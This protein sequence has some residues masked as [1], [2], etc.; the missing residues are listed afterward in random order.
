MKTYKLYDYF[1][2]DGWYKTQNYAA[3][4]SYYSQFNLLFH[5]GVDFGHKNKKILIKC[6]F[7]SARVV[8]E[9]SN[10][11]AYGFYVVLWDMEQECA[12][13]FAHMEDSVRVN[14]GDMVKAG[15]VIGE[16]GTSG[17]STGEHTHMN[18]MITKEG[19]RI[20]RTKAQNW[21]YLDPQHPLDTGK[22][23]SL[24]NVPQYKVEWVSPKYKDMTNDELLKYYKVKT[25][26]ELISMVD[27]QLKFLED[28]RKKNK[29]LQ[30]E[31]DTYQQKYEEQLDANTELKASFEQYKSEIQKEIEDLKRANM[32]S[33]AQATEYKQENTE[34]KKAL[35][36]IYNT[37]QD[38][39]RIISEAE[40]SI[41][42]ED[43]NRKL[44]DAFSELDLKSK[45]TISELENEIS[46]LKAQLATKDL[47]EHDLE[48]LLKALMQK[49]VKLIKE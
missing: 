8:L 26:E 43:E 28:E 11:G 12:L 34:K 36:S 41:S 9:H 1:T 32:A 19:H 5:E 22:P 3:N 49:I 24:P 31:R 44:K 46:K 48:T 25:E 38:W 42:Y 39:A 18:F 47:S 7:E 6:P 35:A 14:K 10:T 16:M 4:A 29:R 37:T 21:G 33:E 40:V 23:V 17:N 20:Y 15:D 45:H 30:A 27:S 13:G 2:E